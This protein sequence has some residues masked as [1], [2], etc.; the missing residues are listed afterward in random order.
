MVWDHTREVEA[1]SGESLSGMY[2]HVWVHVLSSTPT[3]YVY[4]SDLLFARVENPFGSSRGLCKAFHS[5]APVYAGN[6]PSINN[7]SLSIP[8]NKVEVTVPGNLPPLITSNHVGGNELIVMCNIS[9]ALGLR[10]GGGG[11]GGI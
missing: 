4:Q 3:L 9:L 5:G 1:T 10:E 6:M 7:R 8:D 2:V 11:G